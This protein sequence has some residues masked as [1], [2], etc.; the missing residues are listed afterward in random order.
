M[1]IVSTF[2]RHLSEVLYNILE[3]VGV[4]LWVVERR[5]PT[6]INREAIRHPS[7]VLY[8]VL[9][10]VGVNPWVVE[11]RRHTF[12]HRE[13]AEDVHEHQKG[14][15]VTNFYFGS[16]TEGTTTPGL[17][18]DTDLL[19]TPH[20]I[21]IMYTW[22][23]WQQGKRN[24]LMVRDEDTPPQHYLLQWIR[25]DI[26]Q[27]VT[28]TDDPDYRYV[29]DS[30]GRV[31]YSNMAIVRHVASAWG[32]EHLR[33][34]PSNSPSEDWDFVASF[35]CT[36]LLPEIMS[37]F[38]KMQHGYWPSRETL[39]AARRCGCFLVP[40]GYPGSP[41]EDIEWRITP[42]LIERLLMFSLKMVPIKC[43]VVLKMLKKQEF[44]K[45]IHCKNNCKFT[46]FHCKTALFF[47]LNRTPPTEWTKCR[48]IECIVKCLQT[49]LEFLNQ[50]VCPHFIIEGVDLFDGKLCRECQL[51]LERAIRGMIQDDMH[52]LFQLQMD[53]LGQRLTSRALPHEVRR[54]LS[55]DVNNGICGRLA[56]DMFEEY[57]IHVRNVCSRLCNNEEDDVYTSL[58]NKITL[59][60]DLSV[61]A[62]ATQ[63][64]KKYIKFAVKTLMSVKASVT[65]SY[66]IQHG[67]P[68]PQDI[69]Q[70]YG[71]S[72][73]TDVASSKLK[74]ASMH[75]CR[76]ELR[77][78]A[79]VLHEVEFDLDDSV[80]PVC[81][82]S[83][84]PYTDELSKAFCE[85]TV[86]N[87]SHEQ[88]T[89]KLAFCVRFLREEKFCAPQFLWCEMY[90]DVGD[91]VDHRDDDEW[92]WMDWAVVDA[93]PFLLYLQYLTYRGLGIRHRQL[94]AFYGLEDIVTSREKLKQLYHRETVVS[95]FGHCCELEGDV[96]RALHAYS[97]SVRNIPRNNAANWHIQRLELML[98]NYN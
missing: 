47:T 44:L 85:Y 28:H 30:H 35:H 64:D 54:Y 11:R 21:N 22:D 95:L 63:Y 78:A 4:N 29:T 83:K 76:G 19:F 98:N 12:S 71:E 46:T 75:Y 18:S 52:V 10:C 82:C 53:D 91:S 94:E 55:D 62:Q 14:F 24:L 59:L 68:L 93:R 38:T 5:R 9:E 79:S 2:F 26:P 36:T 87:D 66:C 15:D 65:S 84:E 89:K 56:R 70:L 88:L 17:Q 34:G 48:L 50:G 80:Q 32:N 58:H 41:Y 23:D 60:K 3:C 16:Q 72:L 81:G 90:R 43:L 57:L 51:S 13:A 86:Q 40:V 61:N 39:E 49:L 33:H 69:W 45:Y 42:N 37:W 96:Q 67:Q 97:T 6:V 25:S 74:L 8:Q 92:E 73:D 7:D 20:Y 1:L 31:L 27:P 77:R